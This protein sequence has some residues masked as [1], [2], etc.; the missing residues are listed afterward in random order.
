MSELLDLAVF[1]AVA[2]TA[3]KTTTLLEDMGIVEA[4]AAVVIKDRNKVVSLYLQSLVLVF[5]RRNLDLSIVSKG[6][7]HLV[8]PKASVGAVTSQLEEMVFDGKF[9]AEILATQ[10]LV[11]ETKVKKAAAAL[12]VNKLVDLSPEVGTLVTPDTTATATP[13][14]DSILAHNANKDVP[15]I[16]GLDLRSIL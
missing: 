12:V 6:C 8:V 10:A 2:K 3:R 4:R 5:A 9:D 15:N 7:T 13:V 14:L 16:D 1:A 11:K